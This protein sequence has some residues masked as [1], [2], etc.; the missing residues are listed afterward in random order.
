MHLKDSK[1][2]FIIII[3]LFRKDEVIHVVMVLIL[4]DLMSM[5]GGMVT[6]DPMTWETKLNSVILYH[7]INV[8]SSLE[9]VIN[10]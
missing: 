3:L 6:E 5:E 7:P 9:K 4:A 10:F 1:L 8:V 2:N